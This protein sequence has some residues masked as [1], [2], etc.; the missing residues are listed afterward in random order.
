MRLISST[1]YK[2][3]RNLDEKKVHSFQR[4]AP[5]HMEGL[6]EQ[7]VFVMPEGMLISF[8]LETFQMFV[9]QRDMGR[10]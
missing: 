1:T 4:R 6:G 9:R 7:H 8:P 5:E 2:F 10:A 3:I